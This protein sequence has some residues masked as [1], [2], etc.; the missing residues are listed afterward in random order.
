MAGGRWQVAGGMWQVAG[1]LAGEDWQV[2]DG[3]RFEPT[4][5]CDKMC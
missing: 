4:L 1:G 5:L 2:E 3:I